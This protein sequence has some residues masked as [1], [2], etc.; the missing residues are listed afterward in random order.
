MAYSEKITIKIQRISEYIK[1]VSS[2]KQ[3]CLEKFLK[4]PVYRG[5][6][7]HYLYLISDSSIS[8]AEMIIKERGLRTP[9]SYTEAF[10]ILGQNNIIPPEFAY[11]F[12]KIASFRN[13]LAHDYEDVNYLTICKDVLD[14]MPEVEEFLRYL[15][16]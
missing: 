7:L 13:F 16:V 3:D 2:L 14:K 15:E 5:A 8:V 9:Q 1:I 10:D 6:L 11:S 12:A 4:E